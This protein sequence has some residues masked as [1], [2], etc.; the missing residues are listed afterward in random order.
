MYSVY[1]VLY[2]VG[3][4]SD[5]KGPYPTESGAATLVMVMDPLL[6]NVMVIV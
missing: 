4:V 1:T 2:I 6:V 3:S 5:F